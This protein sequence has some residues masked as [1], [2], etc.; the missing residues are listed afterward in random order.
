MAPLARA[1][2]F[3]GARRKAVPGRAARLPVGLNLS[4]QAVDQWLGDESRIARTILQALRRPH[5]PHWSAGTFQLC[6]PR[7]FTR[8]SV[9]VMVNAVAL[10]R[11]EGRAYNRRRARRHGTLPNCHL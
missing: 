5:S 2:K 6:V 4:R 8:F 1:A 3:P 10:V 9:L 11:E 7:H